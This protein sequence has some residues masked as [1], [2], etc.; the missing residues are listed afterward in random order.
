MVRE[1]L[2]TAEKTGSVNA[3]IYARTAIGLAHVLAGEW[4]AAASVLT[5]ALEAAHG[6]AVHESPHILVLLA[7]TQLG[8]GDLEQARK[9][10]TRAI[11]LAR[12]SNRIYEPQALIALSRVLMRSSASEEPTRIE[13]L[14]DQAA[15][16]VRATGTQSFAPVIHERRARLARQHGDEQVAESEL[17]EAHRLYT[18]IGASGH[19]ERLGA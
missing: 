4:P 17:R 3:R 12:R 9:T 2:K 18:E 14:L 8:L 6:A 19:A 11:D 10:A 16:A 1:A 13:H 15:A 7:Q 5:E